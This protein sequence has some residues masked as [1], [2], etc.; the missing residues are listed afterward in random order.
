MPVDGG[1]GLALESASEDEIADHL[2]HDRHD[3]GGST[4]GN[5]GDGT[6]AKTVL[7]KAGPVQ[8]GCRPRLSSCA[9]VA[10]QRRRG[11]LPGGYP[12]RAGRRGPGLIADLGGIRRGW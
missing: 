1:G 7:T 8:V 5:A 2:G 9:G 6:Q 3:R 11:R 4:D 12:G 10:G